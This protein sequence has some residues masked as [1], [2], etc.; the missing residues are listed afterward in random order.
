MRVLFLA[1]NSFYV[2]NSFANRN[3]IVLD[4]FT[5]R[6]TVDQRFIWTLALFHDNLNH[7]LKPFRNFVLRN[8]L[9]FHGV[10]PMP[11]HQPVRP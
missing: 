11:H 8:N 1:S 3:N 9:Y 7:G 6:D 5:S 2:D 4:A 10:P